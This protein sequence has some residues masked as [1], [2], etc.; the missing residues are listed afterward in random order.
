MSFFDNNLIVF[1]YDLKEVR[2]QIWVKRFIDSSDAL[3]AKTNN[4]RK[5]LWP[6]DSEKLHRRDVKF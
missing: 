5:T 3:A 4:F 1:H 2:M 6:N